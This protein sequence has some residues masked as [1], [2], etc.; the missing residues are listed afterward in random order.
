M[1]IELVD[2]P[3]LGFLALE[4]LE[5]LQ[6]YAPRVAPSRD[7][8]MSFKID[9]RPFTEYGCLVWTDLQVASMYVSP[10]HRRMGT[11]VCRQQSEC[12]TLGS[13]KRCRAFLPSWTRACLDQLRSSIETREKG[14]LT[15]LAGALWRATENTPSPYMLT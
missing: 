10:E 12:A 11:Q 1:E 8:R 6:L 3:M 5:A 15:L 7:R 2:P 13:I 14:H 9:L 4:A